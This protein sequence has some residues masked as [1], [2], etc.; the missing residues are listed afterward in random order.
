MVNVLY[1][2]PID[3]GGEIRQ[4]FFLFLLF[5]LFKQKIQRQ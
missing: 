4:G 1:L 2:N 3:L 5:C